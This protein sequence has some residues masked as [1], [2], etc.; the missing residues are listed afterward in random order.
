RGAGRPADPAELVARERLRG[1]QLERRRNH[2]AAAELAH[3]LAAPL[4]ELERSLERQRAGV[5][6][7]R[8]LAEAV[9]GADRGLCAIAAEAAKRLEASDLVGQQRGL[10]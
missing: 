10:S 5:H 7:R 8:V 2:A 4:H 1:G 9:A 6:E 3:E